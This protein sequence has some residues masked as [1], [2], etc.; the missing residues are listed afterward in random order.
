MLD[1][2]PLQTC[3]MKLENPEHHSAYFIS[4]MYI[5]RGRYYE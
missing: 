3:E 2:G 5:H 1:V 4:K